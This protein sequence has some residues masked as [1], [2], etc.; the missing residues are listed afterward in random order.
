MGWAISREREKIRKEFRRH[1]D[2]EN[3]N[4]RSLTKKDFDKKELICSPSWCSQTAHKDS[5][6][7]ETR[8][9]TDSRQFRNYGLT[10][11]RDD[12]YLFA[13]H[14]EEIRMTLLNMSALK[15]LQSNLIQNGRKEMCAS[16]L[17]SEWRKL[18]PSDANI[19]MIDELFVGVIS[20]YMNMAGAQFLRDFHRET[21]L[22]KTEAHRKKILVKS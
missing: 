17:K 13:L 9:V 20:R 4:T 5:E 11:L 14:V 8:S 12:V 10:I 1:V 3:I 19:S 18:F 22:K 2:A 7:P 21:K 16:E 15:S 6:F